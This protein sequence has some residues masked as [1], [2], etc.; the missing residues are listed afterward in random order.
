M[1]MI[2]HALTGAVLLGC[3]LLVTTQAL[4]AITVN[5][6]DQTGVPIAGGFKW[7]LEQDTTHRPEPGV[8][9]VPSPDVRNNTLGIGIHQSHAP[10]VAVGTTSGSSTIISTI[11]LPG[12]NVFARRTLSLSV[13]RMAIVDMHWNVR[14]RRAGRH[15]QRRQDRH[16]ACET[17]PI[18]TAQPQSKSF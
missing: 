4:A 13:C 12:S 2:R 8:H 14:E 3:A 10:V 6:V 7:L 9:K 1:K 18:E 11:A 17:I 16:G 15:D 5:V